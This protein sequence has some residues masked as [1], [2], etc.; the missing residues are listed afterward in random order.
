MVVFFYYIPIILQVAGAVA[1]GMRIFAHDERPLLWL[2]RI[3]FDVL[4][5]SIHRTKDIGIC[6]QQ[7]TLVLNRSGWIALFEP[8]VA[9]GE[10]YAVA[11]FVA[12]RPDNNRR[13]IFVAL[14]HILHPFEMCFAPQRIFGQAALAIAHSVRFDVGFV[15]Y[16]QAVF[17]AELVPARVVG[18][19]AGAHSVHIIEFHQPDVVEHGSLANYMACQWIV[20]VAVDAPQ[21]H[22]LTIYQQLTIFNFDISKSGLC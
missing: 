17:I 19:M 3:F 21:Q 5:G 18:V 10:V 6:A 2:L 15:D 12:H 4:D 13:V 16:I 22:C 20:F 7:R 11:G 1:H 8:L 14:H 9:G